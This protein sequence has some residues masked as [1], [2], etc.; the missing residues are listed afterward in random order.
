[1]DPRPGFMYQSAMHAAYSH[2][3]ASGMPRDSLDSRSRAAFIDERSMAAS[4]WPSIPY[5]APYVGYEYTYPGAVYATTTVAHPDRDLIERNKQLEAK[6]AELEAV[7]AASSQA[8]ARSTHMAHITSKRLSGDKKVIVLGA[9]CDRV[10]D[11]CG[12]RPSYG[13][14]TGAVASFGAGVIWSRETFE[15]LAHRSRPPSIRG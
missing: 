14:T 6:N 8:A 13:G 7:V 3:E 12:A 4:G 11:R 9:F 15:G 1:M 2:L 10:L 5:A